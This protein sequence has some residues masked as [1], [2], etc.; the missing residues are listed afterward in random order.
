MNMW[1][2]ALSKR[3]LEDLFIPLTKYEGQKQ[4]E[5]RRCTSW[6]RIEKII[7]TLKW[8]VWLE[9]LHGYRHNLSSGNLNGRKSSPLLCLD[10]C[11]SGTSIVIVLRIMSI[12]R[13][14]G[15]I[16]FFRLIHKMTQHIDII[17]Q[18]SQGPTQVKN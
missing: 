8:P 15:F 12:A 18:V 16:C 2:N 7:Y 6:K 11:F 5:G 9:L 14:R 10:L 4:S 1:V 17:S 13:T 3:G